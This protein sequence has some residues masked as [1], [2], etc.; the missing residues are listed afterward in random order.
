MCL[1]QGHNVVTPVRLEP[2]AT[3]SQDKIEEIFRSFPSRGTATPAA[4]LYTHNVVQNCSLQNTAYSQ[5][6]IYIIKHSTTCV[7]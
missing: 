2:E 4:T 6:K 3:S 1:A 7:V 5:W